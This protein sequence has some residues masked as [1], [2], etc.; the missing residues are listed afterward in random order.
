[1]Q[2]PVTQYVHSHQASKVTPGLCGKVVCG[3]PR[4]FVVAGDKAASKGWRRAEMGTSTAW[5]L[6]G[7]DSSQLLVQAMAEGC[8]LGLGLLWTLK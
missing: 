3:K 6:W 1:M 5:W 4:G 7:P 2:P 8:H